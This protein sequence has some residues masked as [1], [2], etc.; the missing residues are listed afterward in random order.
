MRNIL[1]ET[2]AEIIR[3][4][5]TDL[6]FSDGPR[7]LRELVD[8]IGLYTTSFTD[9]ALQRF[10]ESAVSVYARMAP[11]MQ[12]PRFGDILLELEAK[13]ERAEI[14]E[15]W[16]NKYA[17]KQQG[18]HDYVLCAK[19]LIN[20]HLGKEVESFVREWL[21][22]FRNEP[23]KREE[24]AALVQ[25]LV[26]LTTDGTEDAR[27]DS[28]LA[29]A[30]AAGIKDP[31]PTGFS[32]IDRS[33]SG[34]WRPGW[35]MC[36][37]I[38]SGM[39]KTSVA[40][41]MMCE[42]VRQGR[43]VLFNSLEQSSEEILF[44][45][46]CNLSG[47][48]TLD[49][50]EQPDRR[51]TTQQEWDALLWAKEQLSRYVRIYDTTVP[52]EEIGTRVRRHQ[53]EFGPSMNFFIV[54]HIGLAE[55]KSRSPSDADWLALLKTTY[56]FKDVCK[57]HSAFCLMNSQVPKEVEDEIKRCNRVTGERLGRASKIKEAVDILTFGGRHNGKT[58]SG[59]NHQYN[60]VTIFQTT[61]MRRTGQQSW[62]GLRYDKVHHRL[63]NEEVGLE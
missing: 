53:A 3:A 41:S 9:P 51:I 34:G 20:Y 8:V 45:A 19:T 52:A 47:V 32:A 37:A 50:V 43:Y 44:K 46:L 48:L 63:L 55:M 6:K 24:I 4:I 54:D 40:V 12:S 29:R 30:W 14:L 10:Y 7:V 26:N 1:L 56:Y 16:K 61:K 2:Q 49:Q 35:L 62:F 42:R 36:L 22:R 5:L 23:N 60:D 38:P 21:E 57:N 15:L 28:I 27:P 13:G 25:Y 11:R 18:K 59:Y 31:E 58:D 39:G 17:E 33:L